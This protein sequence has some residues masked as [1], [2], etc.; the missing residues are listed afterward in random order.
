MT[1]DRT[2]VVILGAG[3]GGLFLA[4]MLTLQGRR[5][6]VLERA[7]RERCLTRVRA[8]LLEEPTRLVMEELGVGDRLAREGEAHSG[9]Y[10][11]HEGVT[12]HFDFA[13]LLDRHA[14]LYPQHEVVRDLLEALESDGVDIR[15]ETEVS[16]IEGYAGTGPVVVTA[17][18]PGGIVRVEGEYV[19]ACDGRH[20]AGRA[21]ALS[22]GEGR[23]VRIDRE[24]PYAWLGILART[25]PDPDEGMYA[26]HPRGMSLH[27]MR[28]PHIT[29]Q[30]LQVPAGT[31][32]ADWPDD[33][34]WSELRTRSASVDHPPVEIGEI[35]DRSLTPLRATVLEPMQRGRLFLVGDAA[36][37]MPP[38]GAKGLN[39]AVS[40]ASVLSA[41]LQAALGDE[42]VAPLAAYSQTALARVWESESFSWEMTELLHTVDE[43]PFSWRLR[44]A[45][46]RRLVDHPDARRALGTVYLGTPFPVSWRYAP[47][48]L[49]QLT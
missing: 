23:V 8:A 14:W 26:M 25:A 36:H 35:F 4:R 15:F 33:R 29:R 9:F 16:D 38:T 19:A 47:E 6:V 24:L 27:S 37:L 21:A 12:H 46:L 10:I 22:P 18:G 34:I 45:R 1:H 39:L 43:D 42:N 13:S 49:E 28:G 44:S 2:E 11:R 48:P 17:M 30:Y 3:P 31:D 40:D 5:V 32:L 20:G 41:A 7:T